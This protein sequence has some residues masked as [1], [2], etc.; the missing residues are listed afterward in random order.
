M[1][2]A[3]AKR[4]V[5]IGSAGFFLGMV[6]LLIGVASMSQFGRKEGAWSVYYFAASLTLLPIS[7]V[8]S[9][10]GYYVARKQ[11]E[12]IRYALLLLLPQWIFALRSVMS[13]FGD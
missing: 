1:T 6:L 7:V 3:S 10:A 11:G 12:T 8:V 13:I 4:W 5:K 9:S 2:G